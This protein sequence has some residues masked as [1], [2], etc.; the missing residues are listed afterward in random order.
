MK[1]LILFSFILSI[2]IGLFS[3][4]PVTGPF[5]YPRFG[6]ATGTTV[7]SGNTGANLNYRN[8]THTCT[9]YL[10]LS[11]DTVKL[12]PFAW[13]TYISL[14]SLDTTVVT[15]T[16]T[17]QYQGDI[18]YIWGTSGTQSAALHGYI[19]VS[20]SNIIPSAD[21]ISTQKNKKCYIKFIFDGSNYVESGR[22]AY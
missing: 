3:Q 15:L 8:V 17:N 14:N 7:S 9:P 19:K 11:K 5:S 1:K 10:T 22:L 18:I 6:T 12:T 20:G 21:T 4:T 16:S 2:G 13:E